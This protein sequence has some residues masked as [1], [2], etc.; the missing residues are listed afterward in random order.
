MSVDTSK[1]MNDTAISPYLEELKQRSWTW[2]GAGPSVRRNKENGF[3]MHMEETCT[4]S[5]L[6]ARHVVIVTLRTYL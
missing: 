6:I 3:C 5:F 4:A 2:Q 1:E